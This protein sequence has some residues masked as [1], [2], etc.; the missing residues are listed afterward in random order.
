[1]IKINFVY[2]RNCGLFALEAEALLN[3]T[4][5]SPYDGKTKVICEE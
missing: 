1:M 3:S 2:H 5:V 4:V